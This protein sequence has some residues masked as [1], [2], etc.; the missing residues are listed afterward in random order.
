MKTNTLIYKIFKVMSLIAMT[1]VL[2]NCGKS[3]NG[4]GGSSYN[5]AYTVTNSQCYLNGTVQTAL[6]A[7]Q[8]AATI[9]YG[10]VGGTCYQVGQGTYVTAATTSCSGVTS[11]G[12][13]YINGLCYQTVN[14]YQNQVDPSLCSSSGTLCNG[15]YTDGY[16]IAQCT[17]GVSGYSYTT[18]QT[19]YGVRQVI[20]LDCTGYRLAPFNLSSWTQGTPVTCQ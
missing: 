16:S 3:D 2:A 6:S 11:S 7:C 5:S 13:Q 14:G 12:Y 1:V 4:G 8:N 10:Y 20:V 17:E 18:V 19:S 15:Y 9:Y